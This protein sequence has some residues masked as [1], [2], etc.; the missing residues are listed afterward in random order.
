MLQRFCISIPFLVALTFPVAAL[1]QPTV[2]TVS[3]TKPVYS[4][5]EHNELGNNGVGKITIIRNNGDLSKSSNVILKIMEDST[6]KPPE[7]YTVPDSLTIKFEPGESSKTISITIKNDDIVEGKE[8]INFVIEKVEGAQLG[9]QMTTTLEINDIDTSKLPNAIRFALANG[10]IEYANH[11]LQGTID[12]QWDLLPLEKNNQLKRELLINRDNNT[13]TCRIHN[14]DLV[15]AKWIRN[16]SE[17]CSKYLKG[18]FKV[19]NLSSIGG[20]E[21]QSFWTEKQNGN[22]NKSKNGYSIVTESGITASQYFGLL[23]DYSQ[24]KML[25]TSKGIRISFDIEG[26]QRPQGEFP[27]T[28]D[29]DINWEIKI[30]RFLVGN[31]QASDEKKIYLYRFTARAIV[32]RFKLV[33]PVT[34]STNEISSKAKIG[35]AFEGS[36]GFGKLILPAEEFN[37][38]AIKRSSDS[39]GDLKA[40][41]AESEFFTSLGSFFNLK[42]TEFGKLVS[43]NLGKIQNTS[44]VAGGLVSNRSVDSLVGVNIKFSDLGDVK[45]GA[46]IGVG[47]NNG[48]PLFLGPSL[49]YSGLTLSAGARASSINDTVR[50]DPSALIS[51]DLSQALGGAPTNQQT[52]KVDKDKVGGN[53]GVASDEISKDLALVDFQGKLPDKFKDRTKNGKDKYYLVNFESC[54]IKP[55]PLPD[56]QQAIITIADLDNKEESKLRFVPRGHYQWQVEDDNKKRTEYTIPGFEYVDFCPAEGVISYKLDKMK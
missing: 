42:S 44:I 53:W 10:V 26:E 48:N 41:N 36:P 30:Y 29:K 4:V 31:K 2:P 46:L 27:R 35:V 56:G 47:I 54:G 16:L 1:S 9:S 8:T 39:I 45:L 15:E 20:K 23:R 40:T 13:I 34:D 17:D 19:E 12:L 43:N 49:T 52:F 32:D 5:N 28:F 24:I 25:L 14:Q 18:A 6:A 21:F 22:D 33:F 7:D 55:L 38:K 51:L 37:I 50:F 11:A 3:F